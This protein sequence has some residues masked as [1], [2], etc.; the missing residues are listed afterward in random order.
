MLLWADN[1]IIYIEN[2]RKSTKGFLEI[3]IKSNKV[4]AY[5]ISTQKLYFS[6]Y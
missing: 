3:I 1:M 5:N 6:I 2:P 4:A